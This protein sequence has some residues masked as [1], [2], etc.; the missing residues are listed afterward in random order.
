MQ[1]PLKTESYR[2]IYERLENHN[3]RNK[4][5]MTEQRDRN[6]RTCNIIIH[7]VAE[8][9][10]DDGEA[11]QKYVATL[12]ENIKVPLNIK[13]I[14]RIGIRADV[15]KRPIKVSLANEKEKRL[16]LTQFTWL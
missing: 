11:E 13:K 1:M 6:S 2:A 10:A 16:V 4:T 14:A 3:S 7:G 12:F 8:D 15:K 9:Q 5:E